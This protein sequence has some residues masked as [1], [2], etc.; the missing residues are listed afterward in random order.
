MEN[1]KINKPAC[2]DCI[3][4]FF[5]TLP[6][7]IKNAESLISKDFN[8]IGRTDILSFNA[9]IKCSKYMMK[10]NCGDKRD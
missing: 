7:K 9:D 10:L 5:C 6:S 2:K 4:N 1:I 8:N 3:H